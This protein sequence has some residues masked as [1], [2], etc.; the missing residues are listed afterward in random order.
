V[1]AEGCALP[2]SRAGI[3]VAAI[4]TFMTAWN[5]FLLALIL[6]GSHTKTLAVGMSDSAGEA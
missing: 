4:F 1:G 5:E 6:T 3:A 2:V